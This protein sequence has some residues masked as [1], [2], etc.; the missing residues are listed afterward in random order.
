MLPAEVLHRPELPLL[1][2]GTTDYSS[3]HGIVAGVLGSSV[4][5][6]LIPVDMVY[7]LGPKL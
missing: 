3:V 6:P 1:G 4:R 7:D 2:T 5:Y